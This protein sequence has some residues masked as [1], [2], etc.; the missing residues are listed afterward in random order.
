MDVLQITIF[1]FFDNK[2]ISYVLFSTLPG[3]IGGLTCF[4][5]GYKKGLY[6]NNRYFIKICIELF[7]AMFTATFLSIIIINKFLPLIAF[8]IGL[9]W[10]A[11]IQ[12]VR[13]KITSIVESILGKIE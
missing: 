3:G 7:G 12:T 2:L 9:C 13:L 11:V 10:S 8:I 6:K 5:Y 1:D 4:L